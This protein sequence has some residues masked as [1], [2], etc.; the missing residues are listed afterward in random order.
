V[1]KPLEKEATM[2]IE[3]TLSAPHLVLRL[4]A[5]LG[6]TPTL[7]VEAIKE[8]PSISEIAKAY[9]RREATYNQ[10]LNAIIEI[11]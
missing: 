1:E 6:V 10:M 5:E 8:T 2:T 7:I 11:F 4:S 3:E 9:G